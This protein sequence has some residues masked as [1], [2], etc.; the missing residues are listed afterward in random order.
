MQLLGP[1]DDIA[2]GE[3]KEYALDEGTLFAVRRDDQIYTYVNW[4]PHLGIP[5]N[6]MPD[7]FL[8]GDGHFIECINHGAL[9]EVESGVCVSG[10]CQGESLIEVPH[11]IREGQLWAK[12][13]DPRSEERR[14]GKEG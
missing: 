4:C 1:V 14:V 11:E 10:P 12:W 7:Q 13:V 2:E 5:L 9:F 6:F 8:D 3:A